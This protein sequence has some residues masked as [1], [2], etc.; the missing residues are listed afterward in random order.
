M[1]NRPKT[2]RNA[3][4]TFRAPPREKTDWHSLRLP[5]TIRRLGSSEE[6]LYR[7]GAIE[8]SQMSFEDKNSGLRAYH[9]S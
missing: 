3:R 5:A 4:Q 6:L 8:D 9:N 2:A 1:R 7:K